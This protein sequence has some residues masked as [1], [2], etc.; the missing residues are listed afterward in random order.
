MVL[1]GFIDFTKA[2]DYISH[3]LL[4]LEKL[5]KYEIREQALNLIEL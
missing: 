5:K 3:T 2:C 1:V 4:L